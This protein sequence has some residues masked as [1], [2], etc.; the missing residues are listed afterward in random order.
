M[1][2]YWLSI[3]LTLVVFAAGVVL[4]SHAEKTIMDTV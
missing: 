3:V 1:N 2:Y 4:F